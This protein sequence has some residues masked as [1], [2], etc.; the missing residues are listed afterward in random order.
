MSPDRPTEC[1]PAERLAALRA[2]LAARGLDGFLVPLA[3]RHQGEWVPESEQRLRWLSGFDG[4]AGIAAVLADRAAL[5]VDGRYTLQAAAQVDGGLFDICHTAE[6]PLKAW[7]GAHLPDGGRV[8]YDP[9]LHTAH[10]M[11]GLR[12]ACANLDFV[13]VPDNPV[14]ALWDDRPAPPATPLET[15]RLE[16]AGR[17]AADKR[18]DVA[19]RLA[20]AKVDAALLTQPDS[21]AWLLNLRAADLPYTPVALAFAVLRADASVDLFVA[22]DRVVPSVRA[23]LG[24]AVRLHPPADLGPALDRLGDGRRRVR[25]DPA[26]AAEWTIDRLRAAGAEVDEGR[27]PCALPKACKNAVELDGIRAAHRRDGVALARFLHWLSGHATAERVTERRAADRLEAFRRAGNAFR[28]LSFPTI[29]GSGPNGAIVHYRVSEESDRPLSPF[30]LYLVDSGA[31]YLDGTTDVTRT[32]ALGPPTDDQRRCFTLVLKGHIALATARF[33]VGTR[34]SQLDSL[35]R[36]PLW[37]AGLDYDHGTGHGVGHFLGVHEGPQRI[38][39]RADDPPLEPGMVLSNEPGYYRAGAFGIR[40]ENLVAVCTPPMPPGGERPLLAF[41]TLTLCPID[42]ALIDRSLLTAAEIGWVNAYHA[43][44]RDALSADLDGDAR[45]WLHDA[46]R[47]LD[48]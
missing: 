28:G 4:S 24:D 12:R 30:E 13:A 45:H 6:T 25:V 36:R 44:V 43:R 34:G 48:R 16:L 42:R 2:A 14:D 23:H 39:K 31:Q 15:F 40:I 26:T 41:E 27:D 10:E 19:A 33:P 21:V 1:L 20:D 46:T 17:A 9:W 22:P 32:I 37:E 11:R 8:G 3:D 47:P 5:F 29:S 35:A 18:A 38:S 7:L